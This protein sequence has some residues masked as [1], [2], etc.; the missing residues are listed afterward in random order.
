MALT[1]YCHCGLLVE[2]IHRRRKPVRPPSGPSKRVDCQTLRRANV[3]RDHSMRRTVRTTR[4]SRVRSRSRRH[5]RATL[6]QSAQLA[7]PIGVSDA[8]SA[9]AATIQKARDT[10]I[11]L[12][13]VGPWSWRK[14]MALW[15]EYE[16]EFVLSAE[17]DQTRKDPLRERVF[18]LIYRLDPGNT[19]APGG[20]LRR[21]A[22]PVLLR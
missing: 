10:N 12:T 3:G 1:C 4:R 22:G 11:S 9:E 16:P 20:R 13:L 17:I 15:L 5:N 6:R 14:P 21:L 19:W 18:L 7:Q 8:V 2:N